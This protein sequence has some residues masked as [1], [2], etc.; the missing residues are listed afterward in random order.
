MR[1][2]D[3]MG[4]EFVVKQIFDVGYKKKI[5]VNSKELNLFKGQ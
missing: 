4:K 3:C 1:P 2:P 5:K